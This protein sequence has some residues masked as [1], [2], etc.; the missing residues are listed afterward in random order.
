MQK[1]I[2]DSIALGTIVKFDDD[3]NPVVVATEERL[4]SLLGRSGPLVDT[5]VA[6]MSYDKT[7]S[8]DIRIWG[9]FIRR[10]H[11]RLRE[12]KK[13]DSITTKEWLPD[14]A[15][16]DA[17]R[18]VVHDESESGNK[19]YVV[20][21]LKTANIDAGDKS[22]DSELAGKVVFGCLVQSLTN[23]S[24]AVYSSPRLLGQFSFRG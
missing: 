20:V 9:E 4:L 2:S 23:D 19:F 16:L 10:T 17:A 13:P 8:Q 21:G 1:A 5:A 3:K 11:L 6:T 24:N 7:G 22:E 15:Y 18:D 12:L 14:K